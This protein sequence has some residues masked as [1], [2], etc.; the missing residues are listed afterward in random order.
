MRCPF[1]LHVVIQSLHRAAT[2]FLVVFG[3][4]LDDDVPRDGANDFASLNDVGG[5]DPS[6]TIAVVAAPP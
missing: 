3:V 2:V 4:W 5:K 6:G 1:L